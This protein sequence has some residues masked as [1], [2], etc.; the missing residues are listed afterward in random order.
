[1]LLSRFPILLE[2]GT[3]AVGRWRLWAVFAVV[4]LVASFGTWV[5]GQYKIG[6]LDILKSRYDAPVQ[7]YARSL[8]SCQKHS[9]EFDLLEGCKQSQIGTWLQT[10]EALQFRGPI[11][12]NRVEVALDESKAHVDLNGKELASCVQADVEDMQ[13]DIGSM[14]NSWSVILLLFSFCLGVWSWVCYS[15]QKIGSQRARN[16]YAETLA[17]TVG[18]SVAVDENISPEVESKLPEPPKEE[19]DI[20]GLSSPDDLKPE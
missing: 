10:T 11:T 12:G 16:I 1:M 13:F 5:S 18:G 6:R 2:F 7:N 4:A 17:E 3:G 9:L 20:K 19:K 15:A 8:S 14:V